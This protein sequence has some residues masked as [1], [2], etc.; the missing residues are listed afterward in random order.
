MDNQIKE[1]KNNLID[2]AKE[3]STS[4]AS[5][6]ANA[7]KSTVSAVGETAVNKVKTIQKSIDEKSS[8]R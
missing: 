1:N 3:F 6:V 7:A 4:A 5:T 8:K 2:K